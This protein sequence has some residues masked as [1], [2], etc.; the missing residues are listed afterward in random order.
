M[1]LFYILSGKGKIMVRPETEYIKC[2]HCGKTTAR[3]NGTQNGKQRYLCKSCKRT[4]C[5]T[6]DGN[7]YSRAAYKVLQLLYNILDKKFYGTRNIDTA[8]KFATKNFNPHETNKIRFST[9]SLSKQD[10][11]ELV[12]MNPRL[13]IDIENDKLCFY[14][15][16]KFEPTKDNKTRTITITEDTT[17][18]TYNI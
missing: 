6:N 17:L 8:L 14:Q 15:I 2:V 5:E 1:L 11:I 12:C 9:I 13:L 3:K 4:F 18:K 10:D 16:P 7:R